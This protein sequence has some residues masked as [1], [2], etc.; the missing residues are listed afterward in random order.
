ME[1]LD[2]IRQ[3][4]ELESPTDVKPA[5]DRL[6][7]LIQAQLG[8]TGAAVERIAQETCG[9]QLR[10]RWGGDGP[11]ILLLSHVDTVWPLGS[12]PY[13]VEGDRAHGPGIYDMK[14]GAY[15]AYHALKVLA[16]EGR[17]TP[18]PL[19]LLFTTDEEVGSPASRDLI[20]DEARRS[21]YVLVLEPGNL[22]GGAV[23]TW[24]K[25]WGRF[26]LKAV[27][28][29]AHAGAD[30]SQG[31]SAVAELARQILTLEAMTDYER[32]TTV[33][34]GV[35]RGGTR[36]NVVPAEAEAEIDLRIT[37]AAEAERVAAA[38]RGLAPSR[39]GLRLEVTGGIN[40]GPFERHVAAGLYEHARRC[41]ADLGMELPE[42]GSGGVSDGNLTAALGIPT[43][44]GL[45]VVGAGAHALDEHLVISDL[46][47]RARLLIRML[48]T[49][50]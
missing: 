9:D 16:A 23:K 20:E 14:G 49:L 4:V 28:R 30:H 50:A 8:A 7:D 11:G 44:D 3:W 19:T 31:R 13:R 43:L 27:G 35:I 34:V 22:P 40:R 12:R 10:A 15:L 33:N 18:L 37:T 45:G 48:Q 36:L 6:I 5:V 24:R 39:E 47:P 25:G 2:G 46:E 29:P 17:Q 42:T 1:I 38:I 32:G 26:S 21:R 41:A